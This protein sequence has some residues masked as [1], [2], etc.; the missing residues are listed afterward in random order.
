ML[1][2]TNLSKKDEHMF[3]LIITI[4][5]IA[6]VAALAL[7]TL[8]YG[9][10]AFN[11]GS[12]GAQA[13]RLINEGQQ[14]NGAIQVLKADVA[15][16]S[17]VGTEAVDIAGLAPEYLSQVPTK[18][19]AATLL[20]AGTVLTTDAVSAEVCDEVNKRAGIGAMVAGEDGAE[21]AEIVNLDTASIYGCIT[22][23]ALVG[24]ND[25]TDGRDV[26]EGTSA[27]GKVFYKF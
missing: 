13:A 6:L 21:A 12:A 1:P 15:A 4:I 20:E 7:A 23:T 17:V 3:S 22:D 18:W 14:I 11:K 19:D 5:S 16:N 24:G 25:G 27:A 10:A 8:Y 26:V 9:G 2:F